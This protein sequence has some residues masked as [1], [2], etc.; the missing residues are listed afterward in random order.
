MSSASA[1]RMR[2]FWNCSGACQK[3]RWRDWIKNRTCRYHRARS[4]SSILHLADLSQALAYISR[5]RCTGCPG[6]AGDPSSNTIRNLVDFRK[7]RSAKIP[8]HQRCSESVASAHRVLNLDVE[9][10]MLTALIGGDEQAPAIPARYANQLQ[11][12][13]RTQMTGRI[14][15]APMFEVEQFHDSLQLILVQLDH[16][17]H[18]HRFGKD[19][20]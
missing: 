13:Q 11:V 19:L 7:R 15:V 8:V 1:G 2:R 14:L 4:R 9:A 17:R 10:S 20:F 16:V 5:L 12:V 18:L 3:R 6:L